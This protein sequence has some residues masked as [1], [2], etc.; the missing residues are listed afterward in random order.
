[1]SAPMSA[2][3]MHAYGPGPIPA[4]STTRK[5]VRGP[6]DAREEGAAAGPADSAARS[7]TGGSY[8]SDTR[9]DVCS[10]G[11]SAARAERTANQVYGHTCWPQDIILR[12]PRQARH[13]KLHA[14]HATSSVR[15][16]L[17]ESSGDAQAR[18][19]DG[20]VLV[21]EDQDRGK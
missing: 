17:V 15:G 19:I 11:A 16:A 8:R 5:P 18:T 13:F 14:L 20:V 7:A 3:I 9:I 4:S 12:V 21:D 10:V 6:P 1:M 2:S